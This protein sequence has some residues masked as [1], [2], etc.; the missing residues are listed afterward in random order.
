MSEKKEASP[1]RKIA[2][3]RGKP[4][5]RQKKVCSNPKIRKALTRSQLKEVF[6]LG[7]F[8]CSKD[9]IGSHLG[10]GHTTITEWTTVGG[11]LYYP[12]FNDYLTR[13]K[14]EGRKLLRSKQVE[15][16]LDGNVVMLIWVGKQVLKQREVKA[17]EVSKVNDDLDILLDEA[18]I[19]LFEPPKKG[20][21]KK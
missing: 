2:K 9:E 15:L 11:D 3:P 18:S 13:G 4:S 16:A 1:K 10:L 17:L 7:K 21:G 8:Q 14:D 5:A 12:E 6:E 20:K 19:E